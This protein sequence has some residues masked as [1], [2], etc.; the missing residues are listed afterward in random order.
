M[1]GWQ[2]AGDPDPESRF[3]SELIALVLMNTGLLLPDVVP[4][5]F[6]PPM[7]SE[8]LH[9]RLDERMADAKY[10]REH[11]IVFTDEE[12]DEAKVTTAHYAAI[13]AAQARNAAASFDVAPMEL[14]DGSTADVQAADSI[15][16]GLD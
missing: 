16:D 8:A 15:L 5:S 2:K 10:G 14:A 1:F 9:K 6:S 3:C 13:M 4:W 12:R 7:F 11:L